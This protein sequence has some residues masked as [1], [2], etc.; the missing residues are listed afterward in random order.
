MPKFTEEE[1]WLI[2]RAIAAECSRLGLNSNLPGSRLLSESLF[3]AALQLASQMTGKPNPV[4]SKLP[5]EWGM[6]LRQVKR[7][8]SDL[9]IGVEIGI[10]TANDVQ[11]LLAKLDNLEERVR[12][13]GREAS[14]AYKERM[15]SKLDFRGTFM[16]TFDD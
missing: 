12:V 13:I 4:S 2:A 9:L 1:T 11:D 10:W 3:K 5:V 16:D 14:E 8:Q 7:V 15:S 6:S